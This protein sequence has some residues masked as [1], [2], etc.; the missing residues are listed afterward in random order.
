MYKDSEQWVVIESDDTES[1]ARCLRVSELVGLDCIEQYLPH[2]VAKQFGLD[3]DVPPVVMRSGGSLKTAWSSYNRSFR[4]KKLYIP[5][6]IFEADVSS[7]YVVWW[8]GLVA[9]NEELVSTCIQNEI[10]LPPISWGHKRRCSRKTLL[11]KS[12]RFRKRI[13][14]DDMLPS[15]THSGTQT[16]AK[17]FC[18]TDPVIARVGSMP[19]SDK[20]KDCKSSAERSV[21]L[22]ED[23]AVNTANHG[24][25][26]NVNIKLAKDE[27]VSKGNCP[28][29]KIVNIE[30]DCCD[31][32]TSE[33]PHL[34]LMAR[35]IRLQKIV[36]AVK[37]SMLDASS[38][39][40]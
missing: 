16:P 17:N 12:K 9:V 6:R 29:N 22:N 31:N 28:E 30:E 18:M 3:Q 27:V 19:S 1:F 4:G 25:E 33:L 10:R 32:S 39:G 40:Y 5:P 23:A 15:K 13:D 26:N 8:R 21:N 36:D 14:L 35:I 24:E 7:R 34:E 37:S 2:R 38:S 11:T 20:S